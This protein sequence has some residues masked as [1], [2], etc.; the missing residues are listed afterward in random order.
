MKHKLSTDAALLGGELKKGEAKKRKSPLT[1]Y[2]EKAKGK[3][4]N[5]VLVAQVYRARTRGEG[6]KWAQRTFYY[7]LKKSKKTFDA[8]KYWAKL[9]SARRRKARGL[10]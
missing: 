2:R 8:R 6:S 4:T 9:R 7:A 10:D 5:P 1:P 3:E